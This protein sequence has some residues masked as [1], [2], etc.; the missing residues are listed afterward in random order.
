MTTT[1]IEWVRGDDGMRGNSWNPIV[2]CS[3]KSPGCINCYAMPI[4]ARLARI[5]ATRAK[6]EGTTRRVNGNDVWTGHLN[7]DEKVLLAPLRWR[8]PRRVFVNSMG[9]LFHEGVA[10]SWLDRTFEVMRD[11]PR[12]TFM[13]LT[14]RPDVARGYLLD[15][16]VLRNV[17]LGVSTENQQTAEER[18]PVLFATRPRCGGSAPS[19]CSRRSISG[20]ICSSIGS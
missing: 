9:D 2:N 8:K 1:S 18:I 6:Y 7:L 17:W 13:V 12:H 4:A 5:G 11:C 3:V 19:R 10:T 16:P 15:K 20:S 14:K